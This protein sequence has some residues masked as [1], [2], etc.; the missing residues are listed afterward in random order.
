M[1][2]TRR[3]PIGDLQAGTA[4]AGAV[5]RGDLSRMAGEQS[6]NGKGPGTAQERRSMIIIQDSISAS[7]EALGPLS[8]I[9]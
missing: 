5:W 4:E 1:R 2:E 6:A 8:K 3:Q 9:S 7:S